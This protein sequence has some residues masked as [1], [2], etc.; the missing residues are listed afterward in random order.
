MAMAEVVA[1]EVEAEASMELVEE[2]AL[3]GAER[4]WCG[5]A[6]QQQSERRF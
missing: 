2:A 1:T 3:E 6:Q 4:F 5:Q